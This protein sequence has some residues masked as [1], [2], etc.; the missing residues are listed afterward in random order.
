[1]S[2]VCLGQSPQ[3]AEKPALSDRGRE[4]YCEIDGQGRDDYF[5]CDQDLGYVL[6]DECRICF[7]YTD[8]HFPLE[9]EMQ[10]EVEE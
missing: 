9:R 5:T 2:L 1:M 10:I 8:V 6:R 3:S 7:R 4:V